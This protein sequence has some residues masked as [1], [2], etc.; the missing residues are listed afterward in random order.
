LQRPS[1]ASMPVNRQGEIRAGGRKGR[2][3][4]WRVKDRG[5]QKVSSKQAKQ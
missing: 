3:D 5:Q 2:K 1:G 4:G